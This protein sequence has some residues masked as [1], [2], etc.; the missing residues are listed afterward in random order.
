[1][2]PRKSSFK[3]GN[4]AKLAPR[5]CGPFE[6]L[7]RV[8]PVA[9]QLALPPNLRIHNVFHVSLLKKYIHDATHIID[10]D[11]IQVEPEGDFPVESDCILE[12]REMNLRNRSIG[13]VKVQWKHLGPDEATWELE[14]NM[15]EAYPELFQ[16]R[17]DEE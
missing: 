4:C 2:K 7:A 13:Q 8:G 12:R 10:W 5:Y 6:I 14:R 11:V 1:M 9:Y 17:W 15:R 3:L 16:E